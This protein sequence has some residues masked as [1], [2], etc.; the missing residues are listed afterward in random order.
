MKLIQSLHTA[1]KLSFA[2]LLLSCTLFAN[3]AVDIFLELDGIE[4][5]SKDR[6]FESSIDVLAFSQGAS[7]NT[8]FQAGGGTTQSS[9][10][11]T[12]M[13]FT[14]YIDKSSPTLRLRMAQGAFI[15]RAKLSVRKAG[16]SALVYFTVELKNVTVTSVSSGGS[17]G[18]DRLTEN[19]SLSYTE[20]KWTYVEQNDDGS[21]GGTVVEG[22]NLQTNTKL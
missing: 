22:W 1:V 7:N 19:L 9:P 4:G 18:E 2:V 6:D 17:G 12:D 16:G 10:N 8:G 21:A 11:F 3:A 15:P 14:K 5:E 13:S 20:I